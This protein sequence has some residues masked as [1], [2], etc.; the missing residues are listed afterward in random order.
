VHA[1][2]GFP[3]VGNVQR[4]RFGLQQTLPRRF[5]LAVDYGSLPAFQ[6]SIHD[7]PEQSRFL[8][9]VRRAVGVATPAAGVEITG[10]VVEP[11]GA[12]VAGAVVTLGPYVTTAG[13]DGGYRFAHVPVGDYDLA[14]DAAHLPARYGGDGAKH[15]LHASSGRNTPIDLLAI[16]LHAI[17][18][19][20]YIDRNGNGEYDPGEGISNVVMRLS[21][22]GLTTMTD[23]D[24]AYGFYNLVPD[25]YQVR[26]DADRLRADLAVASAA[27][28]DVDLDE[29]GRART[30]IDFQVTHRQKPIVIQKI[31]PR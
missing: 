31:L 21:R 8:V 12:G 6:S 17:H 23:E 27:V 13:A 9:M 15:R 19:H 25:H 10:R 30:G 14:L 28:M 24:G 5:R 29:A 18:G 20:V 2:T 7:R 16:P 1:V 11:G 3:D 22:D 4:L 26:V